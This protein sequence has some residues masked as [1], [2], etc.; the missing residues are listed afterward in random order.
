MYSLRGARDLTKKQEERKKE[1]SKPSPTLF[2]AVPKKTEEE[3]PAAK[4]APLPIKLS[5]L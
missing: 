3:N 2:A 5:K 1:L 4:A